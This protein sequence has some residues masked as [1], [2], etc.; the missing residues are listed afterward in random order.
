MFMRSRCKSTE[1]L[2]T[3][4]ATLAQAFAAT[5]APEKRAL[6]VVREMLETGFLEIAG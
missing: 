3:W 6:P 1:R 2:V 5:G 4:G